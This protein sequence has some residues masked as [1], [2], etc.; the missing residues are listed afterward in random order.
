MAPA[1]IRADPE[2]RLPPRARRSL[3]IWR[4]ARQAWALTAQACWRFKLL[5]VAALLCWGAVRYLCLRAIE[6]AHLGLV[7]GGGLD[8]WDLAGIFG[9]AVLADAGPVFLAAAFFPRQHR[10]VLGAP[11]P[12]LRQGAV[13]MARVFGTALAMAVCGF[14]VLQGYLL[15]PLVLLGAL[16]RVS[17]ILTMVLLLPLVCLL[18]VAM[19]RLSYGLPAMALGLR[20]PLAE[21]WAISRFHV[22]RSLAVCAVA[23]L[24]LAAL[25]ACWIA[26]AP[27]PLGWAAMIVRPLADCVA[28]SLTASL[29]GV[30][31]RTYRLPLALRPD[32]R[33]SRN[34]S[35]RVEP[36][37][38]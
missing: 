2:T 38:M 19:L 32:V 33:P 9:L 31:Y 6:Q 14:V 37:I 21:G 29:T 3:A 24:P 35:Q 20:R 15:L 4:D 11:D 26:L 36:V 10:L 12:A 23:F 5:F 25:A 7:A 17:T 18:F 8:R 16:G 1:V 28:V 13:R 30:F 22:M 27:D 34:R